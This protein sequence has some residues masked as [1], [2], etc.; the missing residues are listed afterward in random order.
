MKQAFALLLLP[1]VMMAVTDPKIEGQ[2]TTTATYL[3]KD[4][5]I[6]HMPCGININTHDINIPLT[7][8]LMISDAQKGTGTY[9]VKFDGPI[10]THERNALEQ[11]GATIVGYLPNY[12]YL[13][14]MTNNLRSQVETLSGVEWVGTYHPG[15]KIS[16]EINLKETSPKT[17]NLLLYAGTDGD[18]LKKTIEAAGGTVLGWMANKWNTFVQI[19]IAPVNIP[20]LM[21]IPETEWIEDYNI[22]VVL[23]GQAQWVL[24]TFKSNDRR[25]WD[26]GLKGQGQIVGTLDS[27]VRT[28]HNFFR[29]AAVPITD[30][31]DF[32]TH[33]KIIAYKKPALD[34]PNNP[35][36][37]FGDEIGHGTHTGA[38]MA[39][40]DAPAGGTSINDG[41]A[42]EAKIYVLDGGGGGQ[43]IV[44]AKSLEYSLTI[45]YKGNNAGGARIMSNSWGNQKTR[46][47]DK[48]CMEADQTMWDY[49]DYLVMFAAGNTDKGPNT[50]SPGN[51]KN[52]ACVGAC[53]NGPSANITGNTGSKGPAL[54]GRIRPD[55]VSPGININSASK[56]GDAAEVSYSGTS[57]STP[58]AAGMAALVRQYYV[59]G[60]Y[61]SGTAVPGDT[62][63]PSAALLK[64]TIINSVNTDYALYKAPHEKIGW[65]RPA[66]DNALYFTGDTNKL[67]IVDFKK[68]LGTG[69]QFVGKVDIDGSD[70]P[71]R[72]TLNWTDY[73]GKA[74]SSPALV[75]D[76]NLEV[77]SPS[78]KIYKGNHFAEN[79]SV[80]GGE[81]DKLNPTENVFVD[82][83]EKGQWK[84]K[85]QANNVPSG[86]QPFALV[87]T[88][89]LNKQ[90]TSIAVNEITVDDKGQATPNGTMDPGENVTLY[91]SLKNAGSENLSN[92][93][94]TIS[95]SSPHVTVKDNSSTYGSINA[96]E[97]KKGDGFGVSVSSSAPIN[98]VVKFDIE[99]KSDQINSS[100]GSFEVIISPKFDWITHDVGNVKLT[101][102]KQGGIGFLGDK[103]NDKGDGFRYPKTNTKSWLYHACFAAG[104]NQAYVNDRFYGENSSQKNGKDWVVSTNPDGLVIL[105]GNPKP[106]NQ[107]T[108]AIYTD[109][110]NSAAK[111]LRVY[112]YS[113]G[114]ANKNYVILR[115]VLHNTGTDPLS[116]MYGGV[117][118]DFDM[119]DKSNLNHAGTDQ[120]LKLAYM[121]QDATDNPHIGI[122]LLKGT[123]SNISI[124]RN[125][126]W[127]YDKNGMTWTEK[128]LFDFLNGTNSFASNPDTSDWSLVTSAGP[129][130]LAP[131]ATD[132]LAFAFLAGNDLTDIKAVAKDCQKTWDSMKF[133]GI[134]ENPTSPIQLNLTASP[135][136]YTG[137]G[138]LRFSL[139]A[140]SNVYLNVYDI[141]GSKVRSL[142]SDNLIAGNHEVYWDGKDDS[143]ASISN[144]VY[145]ISLSTD[146]GSVVGKIVVT[147]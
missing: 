46:A 116:G 117:L 142:V 48:S 114:F 64:A 106:S 79:V 60:Y 108:Q 10:Y 72:V 42:P 80:E 120:T 57:M 11:T 21:L 92:V 54:D 5:A 119:G 132:T 9:I 12:A 81:F 1:F 76:L 82:S 85:V 109:A 44:H 145:F 139:P 32:P 19:N 100:L 83:P 136:L 73:P 38:S 66:I 13:V 135:E 88:G 68:G 18:A 99:L 98:T 30:F 67:A 118:A 33:R 146:E 14:R 112:Q 125:P 123:K 115:F 26:K 107:S 95:T 28:S 84:I 7:K 121:K 96:G 131:G 41:L 50:G 63:T 36:I 16:P 90:L 17:M 113:Y 29:D 40:N 105:T 97:A 128:K 137:K 78:G 124:L 101:V 49:P 65:G 138:T 140:A 43:G 130:D 93:S 6:I 56:S 91:V 20:K 31:G 110:G 134:A 71:L 122:M 55:F 127:V 53:M 111:G 86:P 34:D 37:T 69:Y 61:P 58:L 8:D 141:S 47:Y 35:K 75:N 51:A 24:Q 39:G 52:V 147:K 102:T 2:V 133:T 62:F 143:G 25:V 77:V 74:F 22:P 87:V 4:A 94:A 70:K 23:N 45:P 129:F 15:Y 59:D 144:G 27:G 3:Y 89:E 103:P 104:N 126:D